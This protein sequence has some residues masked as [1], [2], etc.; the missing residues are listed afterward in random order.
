[1]SKIKKIIGIETA[2]EIIRILTDERFNSKSFREKYGTVEKCEKKTEEIVEH[3]KS[4]ISREFSS[5]WS[6]I[7]SNERS[8]H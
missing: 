5:I 4:Q 2:D 1:M 7:V 3:N 8:K 6:P